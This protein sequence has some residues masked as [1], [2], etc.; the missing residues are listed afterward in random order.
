MSGHPVHPETQVLRPVV[1]YGV[2]IAEGLQLSGEQRRSVACLWR[3]LN[4]RLERILAARSSLHS[5]ISSSMPNGVQ[6]RDF[7]VNF[8]KVLL[9][10]A[11]KWSTGLYGTMG[12]LQIIGGLDLR[13]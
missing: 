1:L 5:Q 11:V 10:T 3:S 6:G 2:Q 4:G 12:I 13:G 7:A 8:L 9:S